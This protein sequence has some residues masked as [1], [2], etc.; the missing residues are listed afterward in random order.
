MPGKFRFAMPQP[1]QLA[2][3]RLTPFRKATVVINAF[4]QGVL[5]RFSRTLK[6]CRSPSRRAKVLAQVIASAGSFSAGAR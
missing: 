6:N 2:A 3:L 1:R 4:E 5:A